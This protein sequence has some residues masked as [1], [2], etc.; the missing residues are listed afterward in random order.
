MPD[1]SASTNDS[2]RS[3]DN[4][5][6][7]N[8]S[9]AVPPNSPAATKKTDNPPPLRHKKTW[10]DYTWEFLM[11]F[12]A[13]FC[14]Y[15]AE[16]RLDETFERNREKQ[17]VSS[18]IK[19][20][21]NDTLQFSKTI[22]KLKRKIPYYDSVLV[23]LNAPEKFN[24]GLPFLFYIK[25]NLEQF[26]LPANATLSQLKSSG[27]LRLIHKQYIIDS[28]VYY[29][30]RI[31]GE[32]K[33]QVDYVIE[34]NK[35]LI[36]ASE[37]VFDFTNFN[38]FLN[39]VTADSSADDAAVYNTGLIT[40]DKAELLKMYNIYISTKA[41][42]VFYMQTMRATKQKAINLLVFLKKEY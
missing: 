40:H 39:D 23:F 3:G 9:D 10:R 25:T 15:L 26:Y 21:E 5:S 31:N 29:D 30:S 12:L 34:S 6:L 2:P 27:S 7:Q 42:D 17:Y 36:H 4:D 33:N 22:G 35:R 41:T 19:D 18:L 14:S 28:I 13:V 1:T 8:I 20:L 38:R 24:N 37:T 16:Y 11:L 32:Y